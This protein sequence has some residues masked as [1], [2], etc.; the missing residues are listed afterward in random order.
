MADAP[1]PADVEGRRGGCG[2]AVSADVGTVSAVKSKR[3]VSLFDDCPRCEGYRRL[4]RPVAMLLRCP[5]TSPVGVDSR[6]PTANTVP[7]K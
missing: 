5:V 2:N 4:P 7:T 1:V 6:N 3:L